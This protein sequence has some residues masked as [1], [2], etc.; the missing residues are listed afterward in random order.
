MDYD[1]TSG[2]GCDGRGPDGEV[3]RLGDGEVR[4]GAV[5]CGVAVVWGSSVCKALI[6][7]MI[8]YA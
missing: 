1:D 4:C 3:A 8:W 6:D 5:R 2:A 7:D